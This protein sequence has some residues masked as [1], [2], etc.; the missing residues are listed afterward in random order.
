MENLVTTPI[1]LQVLEVTSKKGNTY[2]ALFAVCGEWKK[3]I[4]FLFDKD[5]KELNIK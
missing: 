4:A 3:Q 2:I 1:E 5:K